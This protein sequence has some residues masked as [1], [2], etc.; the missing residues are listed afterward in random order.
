MFKLSHGFN[1]TTRLSAL[2]LI[3]A[4]CTI[5]QTFVIK[6]ENRPYVDS[7][8]RPFLESF[9]KEGLWRGKAV[10]KDDVSIMFD[11]VDEDPAVVGTCFKFGNHL[12]IRI[13]TLEWGIFTSEEQEVLIFHELAHCLLGREHCDSTAEGKPISIMNSNVISPQL[14][15]EKRNELIDELFA[16]DE[17]CNKSN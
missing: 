17:R 6:N 14:Y 4:G 8:F 5:A 13:K 11:L 12:T 10:A 16:A 9:Y 3:L 7:E 2:S 15:K 1:L